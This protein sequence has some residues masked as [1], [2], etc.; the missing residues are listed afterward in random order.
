[1]TIKTIIE[2]LQSQGH[3]I[4][5]YKRRDGGYI[6]TR[7]D[8]VSF[9]GKTGNKR[10]RELVGTTLSE[11]RAK[12]L[13]R[14]KTPKGK[15]AK[16]LS[17]LPPELQKRLTELQRIWRKT[18]KSIEGYISKSSIRWAYENLGR[19]EAEAMLDR[20]SRYAKGFANLESI[21]AYLERLQNDNSK[22]EDEEVGHLTRVYE[23]INERKIILTE[24]T[25]EHLVQDL[26]EWE[27]GT[28]SAISY[29]AIVTA[30]V[31]GKTT[32]I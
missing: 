10:A 20:A 15:R 3:I 31:L 26:Y 12:Q 16:K 25:L 19:E 27:K 13:K 1:M 23:M 5:F 21:H 28:L 30:L 4:N 17:A 14:I 32:R 8:G 9:K 24:I 11:A 18:H 2:T 6:I 29:R 22:A 7:I